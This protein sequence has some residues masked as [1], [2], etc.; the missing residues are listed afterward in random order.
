MSN[1]LGGLTAL[2]C[3]AGFLLAA[4]GG[5]GA[6]ANASS[7]SSTNGAGDRSAFTSC[8]KDHGVTLPAS[9]FT[10]PAGGGANGGGPPGGGAPGG[11]VPGGNG[12]S[13]PQ[14]SIPGVSNDKLQAALSACR[15]KLP[16]G[17]GF[18]GGANSQAFQA[19]TSCL[20]DHGVTVPTTTPGSTPTDSGA[21][22]QLGA[23]RNDPKFAA[24]NKTCQALL[25]VRNGNTTTTTVPS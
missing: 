24:A 3:S 21:G 5:G 8:L 1:R 9:G 14:F 13:G 7:T 11:G 10:P 16:N 22:G 6:K 17:G 23:L 19:Y 18:G 12:N 4:C 2:A 15:S 20:R 25:P